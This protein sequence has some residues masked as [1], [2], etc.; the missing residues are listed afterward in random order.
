MLYF[1]AYFY[2][3]LHSFIHILNHNLFSFPLLVFPQVLYPGVLQN[4]MSLSSYK[5]YEHFLLKFY[6]INLYFYFFFTFLLLFHKVLYPGVPIELVVSIGT[7]YYNKN[8]KLR[9]MGWDLLVNQLIASST[10]TEDV[11]ALLNDFLPS[12][13]Y[14]RFNPLLQDILAIDEK[15]K[16]VLLD[17]KRIAK[18]TYS[19]LENGEDSKHIEL[20][21][22][23]L[24]GPEN[25]NK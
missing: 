21:I 17:L 7:G 25:R 1:T 2:F 10:D 14:Y 24:R 18:E 6:F 5:Y 19:G 3:Y 13:K 15:N 9:T 20:L 4:M 23:T 11:H 22:N 8:E 12:E 16:A